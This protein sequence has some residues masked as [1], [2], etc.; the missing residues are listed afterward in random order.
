MTKQRASEVLAIGSNYGEYRKHMTE[1]EISE[2]IA[3]WNTMPGYTCFADAIIRIAKG[4]IGYNES[5]ARHEA[6]TDQL[7]HPKEFLC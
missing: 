1:T 2:V 3:L 6:I 5:V 4:T 7:E